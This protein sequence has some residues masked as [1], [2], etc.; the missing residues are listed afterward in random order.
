MKS[1]ASLAML[2]LALAACS[3]Q[4]AGTPAAPASP[5]AAVA[6][7][8]GQSW[9][10]TVS[11]TAEGTIVGNPNAP[12]KLVEYGSRLCPACGALARE[13]YEPLMNT[14]VK[15]GKVSFEYREFL[16]HGAPD[17]PPALLGNCTD[18]AAFFPILEQMYQAQQGFNDKLQAMPPAM[19]Q[20]LQTAKPV[21][22]IR[23]MAEQMGLID[24]AKQRGIPE[25]KARACLGDMTQIDR[26]TK[27]TQ[28]KGA[29]GTVSGTP[30]L[31]I[32]G[33]K[34]DA[35]SWSQLEPLLKAAGA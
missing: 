9:T 32:N 17:V 6:A 16:I 12:I 3:K 33:K 30:T 34:A 10:D 1:L 35:L 28:D 21:D 4:D 15:S 20:Q 18:P 5:V 22:A 8:A 14:Y 2:P 27:Q 25:A 19:Q 13:G 31:I 23:M 7:P 29:D 24:F 11:R 26:W